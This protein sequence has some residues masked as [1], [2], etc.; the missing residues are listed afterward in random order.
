[1]KQIRKNIF[2][3]NSSST[4]AIVIPRQAEITIPKLPKKLELDAE[5]FGWEKD[6]HDDWRTK[7]SYLV[8]AINCTWRGDISKKDLNQVTENYYTTLREY[9]KDLGVEEFEFNKASC[10]DHGYECGEFVEFVLSDPSRFHRYLF[11][12]KS[13]IMT[14]NDN[15]DDAK[16]GFLV[17][18]PNK[19]DVFYKGN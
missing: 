3:T 18:D 19:Y 14:G 7:L 17:G 9:L 12:Q 16:V 6:T 13:I 8:A 1:M 4:H 5:Y 15:D 2:E 11:S 10:I